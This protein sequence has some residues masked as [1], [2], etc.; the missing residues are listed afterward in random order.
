MISEERIARIPPS[1]PSQGTEAALKGRVAL[2]SKDL[3]RTE[4]R[5]P[6]AR[7]RCSQESVINQKGG[8]GGR[9][10]GAWRRRWKGGRRGGGDEEDR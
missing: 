10:R 5:S 8:G 6:R 1:R 2:Q 9:V 7:E 3:R 4:R